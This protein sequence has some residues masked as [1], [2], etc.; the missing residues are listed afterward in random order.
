MILYNC[1]GH[2]IKETDLKLQSP[3][4][5]T[6]YPDG[7]AKINWKPEDDDIDNRG[8]DKHNREENGQYTIDIELKKGTR[9][10]R[11]GSPM[12][13]SSSPVNTDYELMALP[14]V[15]ETIEYHEYIVTADN[16]AVRLIVEKGKAGAMFNSPGGAVQY[17]HKQSINLDVFDQK[18]KEDV[19]W[20]KQKKNLAK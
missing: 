6:V 7:R 10:C 12:G 4:F 16:L 5:G 11:Y 19:T 20:L 18:L 2:E 3:E 8:Y 17:T 9:I 15:K 1:V 14:Y 13:Y